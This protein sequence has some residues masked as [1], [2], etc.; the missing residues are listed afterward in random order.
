MRSAILVAT[1]ATLLGSVGCQQQN[2]RGG[3]ESCG[4]AGA[5]GCSSCGLA[6]DEHGGLAG[7]GGGGYAYRGHG[8]RRLARGG[9]AGGCASCGDSDGGCDACSGIAGPN[10]LNE[11]GRRARPAYVGH[12]PHGYLQASGPPG[13]PSAGYAYPYYTTRAPRDFLLDQPPSIGP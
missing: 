12:V 8:D 4:L 10:G 5:G 2:L 6:A 9:D 1:V 13:P 11:F 7:G 3:C